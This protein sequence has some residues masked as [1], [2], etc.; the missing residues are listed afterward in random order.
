LPCFVSCRGPAVAPSVVPEAV[1]RLSCRGPEEP[2][3]PVFSR[4]T[5][6]LPLGSTLGP[7]SAS[8]GTARGLQGS[9]IATRRKA[10]QIALNRLAPIRPNHPLKGM[11][12]DLGELWRGVGTKSNCPNFFW[13]PF[14]GGVGLTGSSTRRTICSIELQ[15]ASRGRRKETRKR[16]KASLQTPR[17]R[18]RGL[19]SQTERG[20]AIA[21][22]ADCLREPM[23]SA[24]YL[25]REGQGYAGKPGSV[26]IRGRGLGHV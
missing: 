1:L 12:Q 18:L 17:G 14:R 7:I 6:R 8:L 24:Q 5:C 20:S 21:N 2:A 22:A 16:R 13:H 3:L 19:P 15:P 10:S 25:R 4:C 26:V 11:S 23:P 9:I